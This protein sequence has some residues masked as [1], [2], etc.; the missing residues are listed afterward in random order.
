[1]FRLIVALSLLLAPLAA[2]ADGCGPPPGGPALA[3]LTVPLDDVTI[4]AALRLEVNRARCAAGLAP[5][6]PMPPL[7]LVAR[8]YVRW[9]ATTGRLTHD[10]GPP[11]RDSLVA[12]LNAA[13]AAFSA[14][15]ETIATA[16]LYALDGLTVRRGRGPCDFI[17]PDGAVIPVQSVASLAAEVVA[18]W[19]A[20]PPPRAN[21]LDPRVRA[22]GAGAALDPMGD[23]CGT[24]YIAADLFG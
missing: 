5:L 18:G 4:D 17:G 1:M 15:G 13:G 7:A 19:M 20:S 11:G 16:S 23:L 14:A 8:D 24:L 10:G 9:M 22:M 6:A 21:L 3:P 2:R 12:R